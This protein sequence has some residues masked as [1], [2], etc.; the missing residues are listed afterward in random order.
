M[1]EQKK[2]WFLS[3]GVSPYQLYT[4]YLGKHTVD[5]KHI[6]LLQCERS[7][8][9]LQAAFASMFKYLFLLIVQDIIENGIT[10]QLPHTTK[11]KCYIEMIPVSGEEFKKAYRLGAFQDVDFLASNF[12]GYNLR[13]RMTTK[14]GSWCKRIYVTRKYKQRITELTN[15]GRKW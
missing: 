8:G 5:L 3:Y 6:E 1:M 11:N 7:W 12:T 4:N 9:S 2:N 10:F 13:F 15:Q 14:Y